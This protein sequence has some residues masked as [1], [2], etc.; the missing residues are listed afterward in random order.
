[1]PSETIDFDT[2]ELDAYI[3]HVM[4]LDDPAVFRALMERAADQ[5]GLTAIEIIREDPGFYPEQRPGAKYDRTGKLGQS[6]AYELRETGDGGW[7]LVIG[8]TRDYA[9]LVVGDVDE[10]AWIHLNVWTP[11]VDMV[12]TNIDPIVGAIAWQYATD[13][14]AYLEMF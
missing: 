1:M 4:A 13:L 9:P 11:L 2:A 14:D 12:S 7:Q 3:E 8:F 10:Q 5:G 6:L